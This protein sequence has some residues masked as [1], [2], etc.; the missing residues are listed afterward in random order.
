MLIGYWKLILLTLAITELAKDSVVKNRKAIPWIAVIVSVVI[1]LASVWSVPNM[2]WPAVIH[3]L[4]A[5]LISTGTYKLVKDYI[6][7]MRRG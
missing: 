3:G 1:S 6:R 7:A 2:L 5:G 4:I